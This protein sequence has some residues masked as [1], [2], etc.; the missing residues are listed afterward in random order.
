MEVWECLYDAYCDGALFLPPRGSQLSR[1]NIEKFVD[2]LN[3][4]PE[5]KE[6]LQNLLSEF[7]FD[8]ERRGFRAGFKV[9]LRL[10]SE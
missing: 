8:I 5:Q 4:T 7:Y 6:Q 1:H 9:A 2:K 10:Y 3:P